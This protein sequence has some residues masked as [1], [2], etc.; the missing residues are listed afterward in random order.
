VEGVE[1]QPLSALQGLT[2]LT[3]LGTSLCGEQARV[4]AGP[5][6]LQSV[7]VDFT[8]LAAAAAAGL[9]RL[10]DSLSVGI[11]P[12]PPPGDVPVEVGGEL[13]V[14]DTDLACFST[15]QLHKLAVT[16]SVGDYISCTHAQQLQQGLQ[17]CTQLRALRIAS[18]AALHADVLSLAPGWGR[19]EHLHLSLKGGSALDGGAQPHLL[20]LLAGCSR[21]RQ[22]TLRGVKGL[23][24]VLVCALMML[25]SLRLLQLLGCNAALS[26]ERCQALVGQLGRHQLQV[27]VVVDDGSLRAAWMAEEFEEGWWQDA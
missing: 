5:G 6:A 7:E 21:L 11:A 18:S 13:S 16:C 14:Y 8:D 12:F 17:G 15:R 19:L 22:L 9:A 26:Q 2:A 4:L 20:V 1:L 23:S 25:P 24:E 3:I 27:D 10:R